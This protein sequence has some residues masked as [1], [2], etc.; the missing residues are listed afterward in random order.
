MS[1][2]LNIEM[3]KQVNKDRLWKSYLAYLEGLVRQTNTQ[4]QYPGRKRQYWRGQIVEMLTKT[5][6]EF[7]LCVYDVYGFQEH[8]E[9]QRRMK[10]DRCRRES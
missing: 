6:M 8:F 1:Y 3:H 7:L 4:A 10:D 9:T 5:E 2:G